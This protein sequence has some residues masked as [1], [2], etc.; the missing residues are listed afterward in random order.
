MPKTTISSPDAAAAV[1]RLT[2]RT[3]DARDT[4]A[5]S[6]TGACTAYA[7]CSPAFPFASGDE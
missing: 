5:G 2:L 7:C 4:E 1:D 3:A 6:P